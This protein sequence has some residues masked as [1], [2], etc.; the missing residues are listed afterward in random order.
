V[1]P[2]AS[3]RP[4]V[5]VPDLQQAVA[6]ILEYDA[7]RTA[8]ITA[9]Q[10]RGEDMA[11]DLEHERQEAGKLRARAEALEAALRHAVSDLVDFAADPGTP[12]YN[13]RVLVGLDGKTGLRDLRGDVACPAH[14]EH[15][16]DGA[17]CLDC[18][19]CRP[20]EGGERRG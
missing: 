1:S 7:Q 14:G 5:Q 3:A 15:P 10:H 20:A 6:D 16:H 12:L 13:A 2:V 4:A 8:Y 19:I 11:R 9:L 17:T 18:P